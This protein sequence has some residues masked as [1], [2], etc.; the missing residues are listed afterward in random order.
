[1]VI[2]MMEKEEVRMSYRKFGKE[3]YKKLVNAKLTKKSNI[4]SF[5][6]GLL[7]TA[8]L[9]FP[10]AFL[11]FNLIELYWYKS[12]TVLIFLSIAW[13]LLQLCNGFSSYVT[14][15]VIKAYE[16]DMTDIQELDSKAIFFAQVFNI[17][18][19]IVT[20]VVFAFLWF[21]WLFNG[22]I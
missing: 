5:I 9:V 18:F 6:T 7:V 22:V 14:C 20:F 19:M 3:Q 8:I 17:G 4:V 15:L 21:S 11:L 2:D 12:S 10:V 13:G 1:M 16:K